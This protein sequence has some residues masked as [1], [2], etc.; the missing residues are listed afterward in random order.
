MEPDRLPQRRD[1]SKDD[2]NVLLPNPDQ[3]TNPNETQPSE[4]RGERIAHGKQ[5]Q[6]GGKSTGDVPGAAEET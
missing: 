1:L 5:I 3:L 2:P 6:R 4:E